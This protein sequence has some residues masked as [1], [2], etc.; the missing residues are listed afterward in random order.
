MARWT[1]DHFEKEYN[2][3]YKAAI[4]YYRDREKNLLNFYAKRA[5][6][7]LTRKEL[8]AVEKKMINSVWNQL[9]NEFQAR[10]SAILNFVGPD[11]Y[12]VTGARNVKYFRSDMTKKEM[13]GL[14]MRYGITYQDLKD[15]FNQGQQT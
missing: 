8:E 14:A 13:M 12:V 7:E 4:R 9:N 15:A 10:S 1:I 2:K 5:E 6:R 11:P 3:N